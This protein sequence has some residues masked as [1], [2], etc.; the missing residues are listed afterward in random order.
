MTPRATLTP[1][2]N[3]T[4]VPTRQVLHLSQDR[5]L[6]LTTIMQVFLPDKFYMYP[7]TDSYP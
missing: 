2:D 6:P 7:K 3:V 4:G 1:N 5:L